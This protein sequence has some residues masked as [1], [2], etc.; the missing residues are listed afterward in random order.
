MPN[1]PPTDTPTSQQGIDRLALTARL[2]ETLAQDLAVLGFRL[3]ELI[4]DSTLGHEHRDEIR[5][6]RLLMVEISRRFRDDIYLTNNRSREE[7]RAILARLLEDFQSQLDLSYPP[8]QTHSEFLLNEVLVEIARN[9]VRH[10]GARCFVISYQRNEDGIEL[11]VSDDGHGLPSPSRKN[12][13]LT[14]IDQSLR[15]I[16][17]RYICSSTPQGTSYRIQI[18]YSIILNEPSR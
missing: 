11:Q 14:M 8:L 1:H 5:E 2:H 10:S 16:G 6:I 7:V 18:P 3:D 17:C 4:A 13:G 15:M 9:S 12:L